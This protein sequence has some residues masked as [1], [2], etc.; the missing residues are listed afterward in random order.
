MKPA[1]HA[2]AGG[3]QFDNIQ[4]M[5]E[6][7][8][9]ETV[10]LIGGALLSYSSKLEESTKVFLERINE[11]FTERLE[12]P[13]MEMASACDTPSDSQAPNVMDK[14]DYLQLFT[15]KGREKTIYKGT[16][17]LP[18]QDVSRLE[19]IGP[20]GEKTAFDLRY[21][22]IAPGGYTSLEKHAHTHTVICMRG[23]G[24]LINEEDRLP[25]APFDIAY[26]DSLR[27][28]QLRNDGTEPFGFFCIVDRERDRPMPPDA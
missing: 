9:A 24:I 10:F 25:M 11:H 18:F 13:G 16:T 5:A 2:P 15:W 27:V 7:Y 1:F 22:E 21:F 20:T 14:L 6:E 28:H 3:M 26:I 17:E 19:L 12:S 23:R 8:G 4:T